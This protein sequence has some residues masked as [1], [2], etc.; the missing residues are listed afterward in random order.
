MSKVL[1]LCVLVAVPVVAVIGHI[2]LVGPQWLVD[3]GLW[4]IAC[5]ILLPLPFGV[6]LG[7]LS[8]PRTSMFAALAYGVLIT[9]LYITPLPPDLELWDLAFALQPGFVAFLLVWFYAWAAGSL[10]RRWQI[11]RTQNPQLPPV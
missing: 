2:A 4:L 6:A 9:I 10:W 5:T 7:V 8:S 3:A 11:S 1:R